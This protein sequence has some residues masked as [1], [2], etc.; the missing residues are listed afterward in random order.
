MALFNRLYLCGTK[1][2][3]WSESARKLYRPSS[4]VETCWNTFAV[5]LRFVLDE[6]RTQSLGYNSATLAL[7]DINTNLVLHAGS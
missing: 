1:Q 6:K 2:T 3:P 5:A 4:C 7:G